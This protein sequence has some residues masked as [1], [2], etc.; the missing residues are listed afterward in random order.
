MFDRTEEDEAC[1]IFLA[2]RASQVARYL[3][4]Y[5]TFPVFVLLLACE[6]AGHVKTRSKGRE[7]G[8]RFEGQ[9]EKTVT[10]PFYIDQP[11]AS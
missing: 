7:E 8:K 11:T 5:D 3:T 9:P 2:G 6:A 10:E 4:A 1:S